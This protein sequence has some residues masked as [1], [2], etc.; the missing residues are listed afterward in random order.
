MLVKPMAE[1]KRAQSILW[2][3]TFEESV[4]SDC[5]YQPFTSHSAAVGRR[6]I[7]GNKTTH[8]D[9]QPFGR[10][11]CCCQLPM[12][13]IVNCGIGEGSW[14]HPKSLSISQLNAGDIVFVHASSI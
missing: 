14:H 6:L 10:D 4:Q 5:E 2:G 13:E 3:A 7:W 11:G 1:K 9:N 12:V 8:I